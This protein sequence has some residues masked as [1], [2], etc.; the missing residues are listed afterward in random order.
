M[1]LNM[2]I[3]NYVITEEDIDGFI[4]TLPQEQQMYKTFP[5]FR[6]QVQEKLVEICLFASD[7]KDT[8]LDQSEEFKAA[9]ANAEREILG[10][11]ALTNLLKD[12]TVTEDEMA[13]YFEANKMRFAQGAQAGAKHILVDTEEK[14]NA[15]KAEI[16]SGAKTFED[17]AKE[18]SSCPSKAKGGD[19]GKFGRG[20]MVAEFDEAAFT[21]ELN[22]ILGP[23]ATQFGYHLI[24]IYER[25][26]ADAPAY[27]AV[28]GQVRQT[29][30]QEKQMKAY[31]EKMAAL[32]EKYVK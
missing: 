15:I 29:M 30:L 21:G 11:M 10:Q 18:Y 14:A 32:K 6:E 2:N 22:T 7:A 1:S 20:Q 28:K 27:E 9:M 5:Q 3:G 17:A 8:G 12:I 19:L 26:D 24:Y 31:D 4:D 23:V 16:E 13:A 25:T